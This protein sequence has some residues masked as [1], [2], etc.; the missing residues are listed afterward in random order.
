VRPYHAVRPLLFRL[1]PERA[2]HLAV[3]ATATLES[4]LRLARWNPQPTTDPRLQ[5]HICGI[6]FPNPI[7]L[8]AGFDKDARA[9]HAWPLF[10][11]GFAELGTITRHPQ[12]GNPR[13]RL[14]RLPADRALVNRLGFNNRGADAAAARLATTLHRKRPRIPLGINLGKSKITALADAPEDYR[15]SLGKLFAHADYVTINVS[16][17]NTPGLRD[18]QAEGELARLIQVT[19]EACL[20]LAHTHDCAPRPLFVKVAPDLDDD[21]LSRLVEV[22]HANEATG[23]IAT[24]T[25]I[26]RTGLRSACD[27]AGGLSGAPLRARATE[28]VRL[29]RRRAGAAMPI[30]GVGGVF[31]AEDAYEKIRAGADLVQIYSAMVYEGPFL[32]GRIARDLAC[33]L[34][35]D[36]YASVACA[37]GV[38][39]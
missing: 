35:R 10:G 20:Q 17:P 31:T 38:D 11:F 13:P 22:V 18:L 2:H 28:V 25:T 4:L 8:A 21:A 30:I 29:L 7:G 9:P 34:E 39:A 16:S 27:E 19:R 36:G 24:N 32:A 1:D 6:E 37:V 5:Q 12:P 33:L 3:G 15:Y 14:F 26:A 23:L